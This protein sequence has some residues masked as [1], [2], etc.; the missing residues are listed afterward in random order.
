MRL[1]GFSLVEL[2][3]ALLISSLLMIGVFTVLFGA[4]A[5]YRVQDELT[6]TQENARF[7]AEFIGRD[8]RV[9][10]D[11]GCR[12]T[13]PVRAMIHSAT[14]WRYDLA[15]AIRGYRGVAT[16]PAQFGSS[17]AVPA[18]S[19]ALHDPDAISLVRVATDQALAVTTESAGELTLATS[20]G[21]LQGSIMAAGD[22]EQVSLFQVSHDDT[23]STQLRHAVMGGLVPGNC[24]NRLGGDCVTPIPAGFGSGTNVMPLV[25]R[26]YY[27]AQG[28]GGVPSLYRVQMTQQGSVD[29][30]EL[31]PGVEDMHIW[32][33]RDSDG[34]GVVNQWHRAGSSGLSMN[35][36][37]SARLDFLLRTLQA[38]DSSVKPYRWA[39]STLTPNDGHVR[40][41]FS[42]TINL[43]N[44]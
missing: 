2:M 19:N 44:R 13:L 1:R 30:D 40:R 20:H 38:P 33:G 9:A 28:L 21:F 25:S 18:Y 32:L 23:G 4:Q 6:R 12:P 22:C 11:R 34:D 27:L 42:M 26:A 24:A 3:V 36:I 29:R 35:D 41:S 8:L 15:G 39:G 7:A 5:S 37:V 14:D 43:R 17:A 31:V 16:F 10:G